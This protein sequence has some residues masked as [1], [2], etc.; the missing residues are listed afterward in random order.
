MSRSERVV[1]PWRVEMRSA[2]AGEKWAMSTS[3]NQLET[4][5]DVGPSGT[6][7]RA[8]R[9]TILAIDEPGHPARTFA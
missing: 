5:A 2:S 6:K 3:V 8:V 9:L 1:T 4:G 7:S